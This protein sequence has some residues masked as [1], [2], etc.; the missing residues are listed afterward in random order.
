MNFSALYLNIVGL[1]VIVSLCVMD[2][3]VIYGVYSGCDLLTDKKITSNDQV[4]SYYTL[5]L[6]MNHIN[7]SRIRRMRKIK[8]DN[9]V[10][11][12]KLT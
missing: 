3:L 5:G 6:Y 2:G 12:H 11:I 9:F 4:R 7:T 10:R 8:K 1:I